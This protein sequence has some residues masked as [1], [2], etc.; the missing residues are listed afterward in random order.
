[1]HTPVTSKSKL[2]M[3]DPA[4]SVSNILL[5]YFL[6]HKH[7]KNI[8]IENQNEEFDALVSL[9]CI[10]LQNPQEEVANEIARNLTEGG[11]VILFTLPPPLNHFSYHL[12]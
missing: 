8:R 1:M 3:T 2:I 9:N 12:L 11:G 6:F 5:F 7:K 4:Q 10:F